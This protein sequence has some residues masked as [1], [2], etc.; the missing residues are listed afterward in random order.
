MA[1]DDFTLDM[2]TQ[3]FGLR[4]VSKPGVFALA[5]P[6]TPSALL[7][8]TLADTLPLALSVGTEKARS[9]FIIAPVL[10]ETRRQLG[11][12]ISVFSGVDFT[13][14]PDVGLG[15]VCDYLLSLSPL[16]LFVQA[17]VVAVVEAK[18][19]NL[20]SGLGQCVAE[21]LAAQRF[22]ARRGAEL[23]V[24]Y[25]VVTT[26]SN[27]KFLR[28]SGSEVIVDEEEYYIQQPQ[29]ILGILVFM[30]REALEQQGEAPP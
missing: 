6:V 25:G 29:T 22:N 12:Q 13:V 2:L 1:Y 7:E 19:E 8:E 26:G 17:P 9:E 18:N 24:L 3:Q 16:Q 11:H 27:W 20:R 4:V 23:P 15:G 21:M 10:A 30:V 14:D 28:L 5:P